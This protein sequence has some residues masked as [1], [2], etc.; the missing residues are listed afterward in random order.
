VIFVTVGMQLP[1]D[2][3]I[4]AMDRVAPDLPMPVVAQTGQSIIRPANIETHA[5]LAPNA[6]EELAKRARVIVAHAGIG[7][8]LTSRRLGK[9]I[10][11]LPRRAEFDEHRNDHQLATA[12]QLDGNAGIFVAMDTADLS[13]RIEQALSAG[14]REATQSPTIDSLRAAVAHFI[15]GED[16]I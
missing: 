15:D 6:F 16:T 12:R 4:G 14:P 1:F 5:A 7:S 11:I 10:V 8:I 3:L 13:R 2:R 9:P